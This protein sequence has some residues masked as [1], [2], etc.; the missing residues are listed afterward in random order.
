MG[1]MYQFQPVRSPRKTWAALLRKRTCLC[2]LGTSLLEK[3]APRI[4]MIAK[5]P[6]NTA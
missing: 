3:R 5:M 4:Q 2:L 6:T 1:I